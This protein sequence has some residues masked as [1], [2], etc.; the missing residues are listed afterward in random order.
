MIVRY[1]FISNSSTSSFCIYGARFADKTDLRSF[2]INQENK[3]EICPDCEETIANCECEC[4]EL[5]DFISGLKNIDIY[6]P[7]EDEIY[8][9]RCLS[10]IM[11]FE[12]VEDFKN[13][14]KNELKKV[15]ELEDKD[16]EVFEEGYPN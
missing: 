1:G 10:N 9:G 15:F 16:F 4:C 5:E 13:E 2:L 6:R 8:V 11:K 3:D 12:K 7:Y 14:V